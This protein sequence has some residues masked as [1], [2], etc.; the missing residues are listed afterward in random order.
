MHAIT[1]FVDNTLVVAP[2]LRPLAF[3]AS[4]GAFEHERWSAFLAATRVLIAS[5]D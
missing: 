3:S 2:G 4:A 5:F 1:T